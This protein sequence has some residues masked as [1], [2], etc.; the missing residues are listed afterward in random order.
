MVTMSAEKESTKSNA[1]FM[2]CVDAAPKQRF[3][4]KNPASSLKP[5]IPAAYNR[6]PMPPCKE[7]ESCLL[8]SF[9]IDKLRV[10]DLFNR[11]SQ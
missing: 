3:V 7:G 1:K 4:L 2:E 9:A 10:G 11:A 8:A 6:A 5:P